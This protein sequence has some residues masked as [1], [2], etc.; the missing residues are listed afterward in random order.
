[1]PFLSLYFFTI[2]VVKK[3]ANTLN[4]PLTISEPIK[5]TNPVSLKLSFQ[6]SMLN[7]M[8]L[9]KIMEPIL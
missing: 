9:P 2:N 8:F 5:S 7:S 3:Y 4:V 1:M 6:L